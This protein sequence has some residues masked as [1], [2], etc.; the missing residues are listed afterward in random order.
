M[1]LL[2][3][4]QYNQVVDSVPIVCVDMVPIKIENGKYYFGVIER[5]T[6]PEIGKLALVGGRIYRDETI[7]EAIKR[8][9]A[10]DLGI[11]DFSFY[12]C[13]DSKPIIVKQY[14]QKSEVDGDY[15]YDPTKHA[16]ALTYAITINGDLHPANEASDFV[17]LKNSK[18]HQ[19]GYG[20][21]KVID[22]FV[23]FFWPLTKI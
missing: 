3:K 23:D 15:L 12:Q 16:V 18:D 9:L 14:M 1:R 10:T 2:P 17:W 13:E 8:T 6:G 22:Y 11:N 20:H 5:N 21:E 4:E 19:F 7:T